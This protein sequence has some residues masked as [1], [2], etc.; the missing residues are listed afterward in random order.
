V[1]VP[2]GNGP[3]QSVE[4]TVGG[5]GGPHLADCG[6]SHNSHATDPPSEVDRAGSARGRDYKGNGGARSNGSQEHKRLMSWPARP[7]LHT[8]LSSA[9]ALHSSSSLTPPSLLL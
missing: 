8:V 4:Q 7:H 3:Q 5:E 1:T 9:A 6:S 2:R